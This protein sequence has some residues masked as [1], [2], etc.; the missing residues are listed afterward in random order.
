MMFK[1]LIKRVYGTFLPLVKGLSLAGL[2]VL[3]LAS[4]AL[5]SPATDAIDKFHANLLETMKNAETWGYQKRREF[6]SGPVAE[7]FNADLMVRLASTGRYWKTFSAEEQAELGQAFLA[8][9]LSNYASRF[10]GFSGQ[11]FVTVSEEQMRG[12]RV[13]VKT[14][15][16]NKGEEIILN[17]VLYP[18]PGGGYR[19]IDVFQ[20][21]SVSELAIRK[22]EFSPILRDQGFTGLLSLLKQMVSKL[23]QEAINPS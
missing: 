6:L 7:T 8:F 3:A 21:G 13:M 19:V 1:L 16:L 20:R 15:L 17:Y 10:K 11:E 2:M 14:K 12:T 22:S 5:A 23:E 18:D 9:T 4:G